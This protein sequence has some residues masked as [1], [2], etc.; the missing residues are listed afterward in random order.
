MHW[1]NCLFLMLISVGIVSCGSKKTALSGGKAFSM[2]KIIKEHENAA[3]D[4]NTLRGKL[5]AGYATKDQSQSITI[6]IRMEKDKA[7]WLSAKLAGIIPL[8]KALITPKEVK[9]YEKINK[10]YFS[11]DFRLLS[12]WLGTKLDFEKVQN[13]LTGQ[14]IYELNDNEYRLEENDNGYQFQSEE[15]AFLTKLFLLNPKT[16]KTEAQQL[17]R[18]KENQSVTVTYP[19]YQE[20]SGFQ[21]PKKISIIANQ[22]GENTKIDI[23]YRSLEFEVPVDF[24]FSIPSGYKEITIE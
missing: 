6:S 4:F 13:L 15:E 22:A 10:T 23:E 21:F 8:A 9:Y 1:K 12:E 17:V 14:T 24:P 19:E 18:E 20:I 5:R 16:F 2:K 3:P 7:I 11:G